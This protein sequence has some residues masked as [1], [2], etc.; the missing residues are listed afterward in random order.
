M[1]SEAEL[2]AVFWALSNPTR[3]QMLVWLGV[4]TRRGKWTYYRRDEANIARLLETLRGVF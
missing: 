1:F 3:R 2:L 4:A